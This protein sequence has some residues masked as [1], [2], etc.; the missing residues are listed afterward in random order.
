M[1][2][3]MS[4]EEQKKNDAIAVYT[5][6][7]NSLDEI[8]FSYDADDD[9]LVIRTSVTGDDVPMPI[10][11]N[12]DA[13]MQIIYIVSPFPVNV[14]DELKDNIA[15][16]LSELNNHIVAGNFDFDYDKGIIFYRIT[17]FF[18]K[19]IISK[20]VFVE[21]IFLILSYVDNYNDRFLLAFKKDLSVTELIDFLRE[22]NKNE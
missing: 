11:I 20:E 17:N 21:M 18:T 2:K 7:R 3:I 19:S 22:E 6:I 9:E 13:D 14:P 4:E 10:T 15:V 12:V 5:M 1:N 16:A 8:E